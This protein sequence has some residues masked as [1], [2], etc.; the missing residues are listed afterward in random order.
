MTSEIKQGN[1]APYFGQGNIYEKK[2][3]LKIFFC[4]SVEL[5]YLT[6]YQS[7]KLLGLDRQ[8]II[9]PVSGLS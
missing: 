3:W 2:I 5:F 6:L 4:D 7:N 1:T 8:V 9:K